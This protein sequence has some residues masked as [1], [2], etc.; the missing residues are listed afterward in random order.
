MLRW[1]WVRRIDWAS[2]PKPETSGARRVIRLA[3]SAPHRVDPLIPSV[4]ASEVGGGGACGSP[5]ELARFLGSVLVKDTLTAGQYLLVKDPGTLPG[6]VDPVPAR[7]C[8][9][10]QVD[11]FGF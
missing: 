6:K 11:P 10:F 8:L 5:E 1:D 3:T 4:F 2:G 7:V 9:S